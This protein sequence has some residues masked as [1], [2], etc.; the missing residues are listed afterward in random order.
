MKQLPLDL[1]DMGDENA[2]LAESLRRFKARLLDRR[3]KLLGELKT[4]GPATKRA[5]L[6]YGEL[7]KGVGQLRAIDVVIAS[8]EGKK[9]SKSTGGPGESPGKVS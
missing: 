2:K 3:G 7:D 8:L 6:I 4:I 1:P 5:G 9:Q